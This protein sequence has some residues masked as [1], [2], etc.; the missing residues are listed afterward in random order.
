MALTDKQI[1]VLNLLIYENK[2]KKEAAEAVG[3]SAA[4]ISNWFAHPEFLKTFE[5]MRAK[6]LQEASYRALQ[7][8]IRLSIEAQSE[9]VR[10]AAAKDIMSRAGMDAIT[11]QE[12]TQKT[13]TVGLEEDEEDDGNQ[14]QHQAEEELIQQDISAPTSELPDKV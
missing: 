8:M 9:N 1:T 10:V 4:T 14:H 13:I 7:E 2:L 3:V 6:L 5:E 12:I 11:K